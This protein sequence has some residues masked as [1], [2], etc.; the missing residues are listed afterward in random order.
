MSSRLDPPVSKFSKPFHDNACGPFRHLQ[1]MPKADGDSLISKGWIVWSL[2]PVSRFSGEESQLSAT[3]LKRRGPAFNVA[4]PDFIA[5][6]P[7]LE[8]LA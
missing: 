3:D 5:H 4:C 7:D 2:G 8:A 1:F 6:L